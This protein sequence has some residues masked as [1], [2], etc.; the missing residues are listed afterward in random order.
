MPRVTLT[1]DGC[2]LPWITEH[3]TDDQADDFAKAWAVNGWTRDTTAADVQPAAPAAPEV[4]APAP[5]D[6]PAPAGPVTPEGV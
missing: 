6:V 5:V 2:E 1:H 4:P 3:D